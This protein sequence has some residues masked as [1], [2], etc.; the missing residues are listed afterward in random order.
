MAFLN[1][2]GDLLETGVSSVFHFTQ[3]CFGFK[4]ARS[5]G[6][7]FAHALGR[8]RPANILTS[9]ILAAEP[10]LCRHDPQQMRAKFKILNFFGRKSGLMHSNLL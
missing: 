4:D 7:A 8:V 1:N 3:F 6:L 2:L 10:I 9:H 5:V